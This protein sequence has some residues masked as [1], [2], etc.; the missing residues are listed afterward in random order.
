MFGC[1]T[2]FC[3]WREFNVINAHRYN[4]LFHICFSLKSI[5]T[6]KIFCRN[7]KRPY[8]CSAIKSIH[9]SIMNT[10]EIAIKKSVVV[11]YPELQSIEQGLDDFRQGKVISHTQAKQ[12]YEKW[13]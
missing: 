8:F 12:R 6:K 13:L 2:A 11:P 3:R 1:G 4:S 9:Q 7:K 5:K 10:F